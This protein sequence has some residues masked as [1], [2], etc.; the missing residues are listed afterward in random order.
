[1]KAYLRESVARLRGRVGAG[2]AAVLLLFP[3]S[4]TVLCIASSGYVSIQDINAACHAH[5]HFA[6]PSA[7]VDRPEPGF[8]CA[9]VDQD[10]TDIFM[11]PNGMGGILALT[12]SVAPDSSAQTISGQPLALDTFIPTCVSATSCEHCSGID[13]RLSTR[14]SVSSSVPMRC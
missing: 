10:C 4:A 6:I 3:S 2:V 5:T 9:R 12:C 1:M 11:T 13:K 14:D 8:S 7:P